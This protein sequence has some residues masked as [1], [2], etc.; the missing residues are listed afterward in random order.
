M[1]LNNLKQAP[2]NTTF[3]GALRGALDYYGSSVSDAV[4]YGASGHAFVLNIHRSLCPSGPYCWNRQPVEALL[5]NLGLR[6]EPLGFFHAGSGAAERDQAEKRLRES[7]A[8]AIPC[9]LVN[10]EFQLILGWDDTGFVT[11]QPWPCL[12]F[13][14]KHLVF[15]SWCELGNEIH[16]SL[17]VLHRTEP[18][19]LRQAVRDSLRYAADLW[20]NPEAHSGGDYGVGP[21]GYDH[22]LGAVRAGHG[23]SHGAW[24]NGTVWTE[25][26]ARAADYLGEIAGLLPSEADGRALS[27]DYAR[28]AALLGQCADKEVDPQAK[29]KLLTEAAELEAACVARIEKVLEA[30]G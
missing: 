25:C 13:P 29:A 30:M 3:M 2:F 14:P 1:Q 12:D 17:Y 22:W 28:I 23:S 24:W 4:L 8:G 11:A 26:R 5:T 16:M 20:R 9:L 15:G 6:V 21:K 7:L 18:A 10:M 19:D 27:E